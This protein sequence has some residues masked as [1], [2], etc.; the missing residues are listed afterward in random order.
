[1]VGIAALVTLFTAPFDPN[2]R[3][4]HYYASFWAMMYIY[5]NPFWRVTY[6]GRENIDPNKT[7]VLVAN[8]AS[9][10]DIWVLYGLYKPFKWVSKETIFNVP[11]IGLNMRLNQYVEIKRGDMKSIKEMMNTC[12]NWLKRGASIMLFPEGTRSDDGEIHAFRDGAFRLAVDCNVPVVPIIVKGT[13]EIFPKESKALNFKSDI[14]VRVLP[15]VYAEDFDRSSG[16]M[17][18]HVQ[19]LIMENYDELRGIKRI[20]SDSKA[21]S[22]TRESSEPAATQ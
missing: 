1:M 3:I 5:S 13:Y 22:E 19:E 6:E 12:K 16:R 9:F 10:W 11:F 8:H 2:R 15:P 7:Y 14:V 17:R 18:K 4:L 21:A 20:P